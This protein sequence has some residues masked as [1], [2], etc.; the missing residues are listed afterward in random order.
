MKILKSHQT[1][2]SSKGV[3]ELSIFGSVARNENTSKSDIDILVD[4]D[5]KS[6]CSVN[7]TDYCWSN[8]MFTVIAP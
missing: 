4:F 5:S 3:K 7:L 1:I 2:L 8:M 6:N